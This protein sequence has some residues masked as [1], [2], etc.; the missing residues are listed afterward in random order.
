MDYKLVFTVIGLVIS[1]VS[2]G[3]AISAKKEAKETKMLELAHQKRMQLGAHLSEVS[4]LSNLLRGVKFNE[5]GYSDSYNRIIEFRNRIIEALNNCS[6]L[7]VDTK[8]LNKKQILNEISDFNTMMA[9]YKPD[10]YKLEKYLNEN[11]S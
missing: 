4:Y 1:F 8:T 11:I 3:L 5:E 10:I 7:Q 2:L 6:E 9:V